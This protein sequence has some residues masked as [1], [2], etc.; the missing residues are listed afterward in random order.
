MQYNMNVDE[1]YTHTPL[2]LGL[3]YLHTWAFEGG[4]GEGD[5]AHLHSDVVFIRTVFDVVVSF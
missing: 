3:K 5:G 2:R 1:I 4:V